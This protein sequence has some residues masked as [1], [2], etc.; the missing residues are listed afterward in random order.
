MTATS[1][2][3]IRASWTSLPEYGRHGNIMG[4]KLFYRQKGSVDNSVM[5]SVSGAATLTKDFANL[6]KYTKYEFQVLAIGSHGEGPKSSV[7]VGQTLEDGKQLKLNSVGCKKHFFQK[8]TA[9]LMR[10][11]YTAHVHLAGLSELSYHNY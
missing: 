5:E 2:T 6:N 4:Y 7:T 3:S 10:L 9:F 11:E 1:S 8:N